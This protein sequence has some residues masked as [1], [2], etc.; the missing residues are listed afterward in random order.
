[1]L[2]KKSVVKKTLPKQMKFEAVRIESLIE[3][4]DAIAWLD[5]PSSKAIAQFA[6]LD[7]RTVG[8]ILKMHVKLA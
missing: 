2:R 6:A 3:V 1:M 7:P 4:L 8:K 5:T